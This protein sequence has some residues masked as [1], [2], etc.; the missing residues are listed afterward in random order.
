VILHLITQ[1]AALDPTTWTLHLPF[2]GPDRSAPGI[3]AWQT[4]LRVSLS[5][6]LDSGLPPAALSIENLD[7]PFAWVED[8]VADLGLSVCL[9]WAT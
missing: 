3:E 1:A 2:D 8:I 4:R 6:I 7:Y 9:D 5:R